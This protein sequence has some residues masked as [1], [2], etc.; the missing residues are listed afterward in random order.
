MTFLWGIG[1]GLLTFSVGKPLE[2]FICRADLA[3]AQC[4]VK[5]LVWMEYP[6]ALS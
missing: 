6:H 1:L 2:S 4:W 3:R 5:P